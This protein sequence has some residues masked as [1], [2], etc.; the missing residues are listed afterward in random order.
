MIPLS[1]YATPSPVR[2]RGR[3]RNRPRSP[4]PLALGP[5][6]LALG[7]WPLALVPCPL[8]LVP[9]PLSL[10]PW[11]AG[12][13]VVDRQQDR[14]H[15]RRSDGLSVLEHSVA[16]DISS[17]KPATSAGVCSER[18]ARAMDRRLIALVHLSPL[19]VCYE[20]IKIGSGR[21]TVVHVMRVRVDVERQVKLRVARKRSV[22]DD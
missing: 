20:L 18:L 13:P 5:W 8:S 9:C 7:P 16:A 11:P 14:A 10:G 6:P 21:R 15:L 22:A 12:G 3:I 1:T 2:L 19:D 17:C 4:W